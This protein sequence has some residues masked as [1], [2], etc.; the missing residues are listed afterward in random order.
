MSA[1]SKRILET[2]DNSGFREEIKRL[3]RTLLV[4][5]RRNFTDKTPRYTEDYDRIIKELAKSRGYQED[6]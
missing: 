6:E 2:I 5:E 1:V 3:L 4:I